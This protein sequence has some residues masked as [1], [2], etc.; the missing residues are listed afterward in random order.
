MNIIVTEADTMGSEV[1]WSDLAQLGRLV[2][3]PWTAPEDVANRLAD[4]D[5]AIIN[6]ARIGAELLDRC[7]RLKL[8]CLTATGHDCVDKQA[9]SARGVT[10]CNVPEYGTHSVAQ[11]TWS[12]I[13]DLANKVGLH[14]EAVRQGEWCRAKVFCLWKT[15]QVELAGKTL[16]LIGSGRIGAQV[17][18]IAQAFGLRVVGVPG[19]S[20]KMPDGVTPGSLE[21]VLAQADIVSLHCPLTDSTRKIINQKTL[22]LMKPGSWLINTARGGLIDDEALRQALAKGRP[23]WAAVDVLVPEPPPSD[24]PLL[25]LP[26]CLVTPHMAWTT[27]EARTRLMRETVENVRAFLAGTPRNTVAS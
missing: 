22:A 27:A 23:G 14:D 2:L 19:P 3:H 1:S 25:G 8:V 9:T 26:N 21:S 17:A 16:G 4:A 13:L 24:H 7:P 12:L 10:V 6:K 11:F 18:R 20:G 15:P 5:V